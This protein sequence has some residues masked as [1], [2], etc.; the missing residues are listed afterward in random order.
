MD[1]WKQNSKTICVQI[2]AKLHKLEFENDILLIEP[3]RSN[4]LLLIDSKNEVCFL[5]I[6][7]EIK[8]LCSKVFKRADF[9][10]ILG[11]QIFDSQGYLEVVILNS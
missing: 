11:I 4:K 6:R 5:E 7:S 3:Y 1:Y 10:K 9:S 8:Q 2:D